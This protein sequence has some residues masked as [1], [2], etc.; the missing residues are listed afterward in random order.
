MESTTKFAAVTKEQL[1]EL[2]TQLEGILTEDNLGFFKQYVKPYDDF[3]NNQL[4]NIYL[5]AEL[6]I[7]GTGEVQKIEAQ[8][9]V[10]Q[11][12]SYL[13]E[14]EPDLQIDPI[15]IPFKT[16]LPSSPFE[17]SGSK[18]LLVVLEAN[19]NIWDSCKDLPEWIWDQAKFDFAL[20]FS[21]TTADG[22]QH[23]GSYDTKLIE[24]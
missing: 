23:A 24:F 10:D 4:D 16:L 15:Y 14:D 2:G 21:L 6:T 18:K 22:N 12:N 20:S 13:Y 17:V 5:I 11:E 9:V 3:G 1:Q 8:C 19:G 7:E